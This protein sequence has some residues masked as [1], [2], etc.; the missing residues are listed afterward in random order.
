M[1][2]N[3]NLKLKIFDINKDVNQKY[4]SDNTNN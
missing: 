2:G 1:L 4:K 3:Y